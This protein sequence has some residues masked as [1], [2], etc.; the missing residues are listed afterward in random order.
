[1][2]GLQPMHGVCSPKFARLHDESQQSGCQT[3]QEQRVVEPSPQGGVHRLDGNK[4]G[5]RLQASGIPGLATSARPGAPL[6]YLWILQ[7]LHGDMRPLRLRTSQNDIQCGVLRP[8]PEGV[9]RDR[10][11]GALTAELSCCGELHAV[12]LLLWHRNRRRGA[13]LRLMWQTGLAH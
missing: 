10:E 11:H 7:S 9:A 4:A 8:D 2:R 6:L 5:V 12:L 1:M 13:L 3:Q